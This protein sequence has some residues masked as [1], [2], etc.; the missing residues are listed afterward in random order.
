MKKEKITHFNALMMIN[1]LAFR[2]QISGNDHTR[3]FHRLQNYAR[4]SQEIWDYSKNIYS[5]IQQG[6]EKRIP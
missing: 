2:K 5:V 6:L 4:Y 1:F 3:Y